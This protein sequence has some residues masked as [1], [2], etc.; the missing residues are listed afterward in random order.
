MAGDTDNALEKNFGGFHPHFLAENVFKN[1]FKAP[2]PQLGVYKDFR[3]LAR[4]SEELQV[5]GIRTGHT[6]ASCRSSARRRSFASRRSSARRRSSAS[7]HS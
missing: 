5:V 7:R 1:G 4:I 2:G 3:G 6:S